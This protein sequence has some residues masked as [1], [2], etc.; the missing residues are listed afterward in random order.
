ME[1][2]KM[3]KLLVKDMSRLAE[4]GF[5]KLSWKNNGHDMWARTISTLGDDYN[6]TRMELIV[7]PTMQD[8]ERLLIVNVTTVNNPDDG[9]T[10]RNSV[11]L[12]KNEVK[13]IENL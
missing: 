11:Y 10:P 3:G 13:L 2:I 5:E 7:N 8:N 6:E 4:F 1:V 9:I 12:L